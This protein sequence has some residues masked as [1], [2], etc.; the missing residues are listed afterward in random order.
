MSFCKSYVNL[1]FQALKL[2][3][4]THAKIQSHI[5]HLHFAVTIVTSYRI[6]AIDQVIS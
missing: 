3:F 5:I 2:V 6:G 4:Y 1:V